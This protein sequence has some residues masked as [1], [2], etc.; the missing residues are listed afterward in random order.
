[1]LIF[2]LELFLCLDLLLWFRNGLVWVYSLERRLLYGHLFHVWN[3]L[4]LIGRFLC[5]SFVFKSDVVNI[6]ISIKTLG[7]GL[8]HLVR[9]FGRQRE[10]LCNFCENIFRNQVLSPLAANLV[11]SWMYYPTPSILSSSALICGN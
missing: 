1:M 7:D 11:C 8:G 4:V 2:L 9:V 3:R 5:L 10:S 6:F